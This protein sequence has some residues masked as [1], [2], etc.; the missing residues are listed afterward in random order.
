MVPLLGRFWDARVVLSLISVPPTCHQLSSP[1][2]VHTH[3]RNKPFLLH[4]VGFNILAA[5]APK[6]WILQD[7]E[8]V[9]R[10]GYGPVSNTVTFS[11]DTLLWREASTLLS[12]NLF[13]L[14][15][16]YHL[17]L[18]AEQNPYSRFWP[19]PHFQKNLGEKQLPFRSP[20]KSEFSKYEWVL[21]INS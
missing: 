14:K 2:T 19:L 15:S 10:S 7:W 16:W 20:C 18:K 9:I 3:C 17:K 4:F 13:C 21:M 11:F 1:T 6:N 12:E 5:V 8:T